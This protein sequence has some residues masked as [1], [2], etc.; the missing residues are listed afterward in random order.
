MSSEFDLGIFGRGRTRREAMDDAEKR[1]L[2]LSETRYKG[3]DLIT[4]GTRAR[5][6]CYSRD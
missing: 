4:Y 5:Y 1:A 3:Y 6:R 2:R